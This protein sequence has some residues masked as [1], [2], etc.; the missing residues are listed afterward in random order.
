MVRNPMNAILLALVL[1]CAT[2]GA[3]VDDSYFPIKSRTGREGDKEAHE[4]VINGGQNTMP[5]WGRIDRAFLGERASAFRAHADQLGCR[6][7]FIGYSRIAF[8]AM[9]LCSLP[10]VRKPCRVSHA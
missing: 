10:S 1:L 9:W 3:V 4:K 5:I 8:N 7:G 6:F 2:A